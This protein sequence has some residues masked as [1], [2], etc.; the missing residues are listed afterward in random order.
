MV[1]VYLWIIG[2]VIG[3]VMPPF[4][5]LALLTLPVAIRAMRRAGQ[6]NDLGTRPRKKILS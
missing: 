2:W 6:Y 3:G 4:A 1:M 5:L